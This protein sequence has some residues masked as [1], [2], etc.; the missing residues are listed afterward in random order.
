MVATEYE[1]C[2]RFKDDLKDNLR[3]VIAP[4]RVRDFTALVDKAKITEEVKRAECQNRES[5]RNKRDLEPSSSGECWRRTVACL[6]CGSLEHRIRVCP[7][8]SDQIQALGSST[9]QSSRVVHQPPRGQGQVRGGNGLGRGQRAPDRGA[10]QT[11]AR[12]PTLVYVAHSREDGDAPNI[13]TSTFFIRNV[14]YTAL[15]DIGSTPSYVACSVT[16]NLGILVES[17]SSEITVLSSL[18]QFIRVDKLFKDV[19]LELV[20]KGCEVYLAY[21]SLSDS[22]DSSLKDIRT[23]KDFSDIFPKEVSRLPPNIEVEFGIELLPS[24]ALVSIAPYRMAPKE[25]EELKT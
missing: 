1:R 12:Q 9:T 20:R 16:E 21:I 3:V 18:G 8:R 10:N 25:L 4:Q 15:I 23:V 11:E 14:P 19:P 24:T 13:I 17:T 2:V 6:R 7:R 22:R 5:G